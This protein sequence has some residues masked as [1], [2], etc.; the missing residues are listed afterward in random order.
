M[1]RHAHTDQNASALQH[2]D[3]H[4]HTHPITDASRRGE[5]LLAPGVGGLG[6]EFPR[7]APGRNCTGAFLPVLLRERFD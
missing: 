2:A 1:D 5:G 3:G 7:I 4:A 6:R